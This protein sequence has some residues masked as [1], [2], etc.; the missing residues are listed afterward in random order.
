V[1]QHILAVPRSAPIAFTCGAAVLLGRS[2]AAVRES[3]TALMQSTTASHI[4]S[5]AAATRSL[6]HSSMTC[7]GPSTSRATCRGNA[8]MGS[9]NG[10]WEGRLSAMVWLA[11]LRFIILVPRI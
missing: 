8:G 3:H 6:K 1:E 9:H 7:Q 11:S 5:R 4:R 2:C 10:H